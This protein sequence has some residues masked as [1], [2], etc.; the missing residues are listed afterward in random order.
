MKRLASRDKSHSFCKA[1]VDTGIEC[2]IGKHR[3]LKQVDVVMDTSVNPVTEPRFITDKMKFENVAF[4]GAGF[5]AHVARTGAER[6]VRVIV[7]ARR[8]SAL[9]RVVED[10]EIVLPAKR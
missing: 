9:K 10:Y 1:V 2:Q 5:C 3:P 8:G 6:V 4:T 7:K